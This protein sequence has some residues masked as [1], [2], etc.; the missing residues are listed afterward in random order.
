MKLKTKFFKLKIRLLVC[1]R[2][3]FSKRYKHWII[4]D[5][6]DIN[7]IRLVTDKKFN[8]GTMWH[9]TQ[10]YINQK[11]IKRL[12]EQTDEIDM[13]LNKATFESKALDK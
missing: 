7:L 8:V 6:D 13:I 3:L 10:P 5:I 11:M 12:A 1:W 2:I 4:I 9:G